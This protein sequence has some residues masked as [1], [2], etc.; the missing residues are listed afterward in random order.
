MAKNT[1]DKVT[2]KADLTEEE[3]T[4]LIEYRRLE[5]ARDRRRDG[6]IAKA[7]GT[8]NTDGTLRKG[9]RSGDA[10]LQGRRD[11][12]R[13]LYESGGLAESQVGLEVL[14][15]LPDSFVDFY[16]KLFHKALTGGTSGAISGKGGGPNKAPGAPGMVLGSDTRLQAAGGGKKWKNPSGN[17]GSDT[18]MRV[19]AQVDKE[20]ELLVGMGSDA[21]KQR[22]GPRSKVDNGSEPAGVEVN[23]ADSERTTGASTAQCRGK[24]EVRNGPDTVVKGCGKFLKRGWKFCPTCGSEVGA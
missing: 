8:P 10:Y 5:G 19:K 20:L 2:T 13:E 7:L 24:I 15:L 11:A 22:S 6:A 12:I 18:A 17:L 1:G 21:L 14:Y 4:L 23:S 16:S 3:V 9:Q